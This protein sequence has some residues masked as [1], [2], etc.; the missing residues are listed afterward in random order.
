MP[1]MQLLVQNNPSA[2]LYR[3]TFGRSPLLLAAEA[4]QKALESV[5]SL[6]HIKGRAHTEIIAR[7]LENVRQVIPLINKRFAQQHG[8][9]CLLW[10]VRNG[11]HDVTRLLLEA[12]ANPNSQDYLGRVPL[13]WALFTGDETVIQLL[14]EHGANVHLRI[15]SPYKYHDEERVTPLPIAILH[16]S[17]TIVAKL[18]QR[19]AG[20]MSTADQKN[21]LSIAADDANAAVVKLLL[22]TNIEID[23]I[24]QQLEVT[25]AHGS[26]YQEVALLLFNKV[27]GQYHMSN[28]DLLSLAFS[29]TRR[30]N[31]QVV[32]CFLNK[33]LDCNTRYDT[34]LYHWQLRDVTIG[35]WPK[36]YWTMVPIQG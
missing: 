14:L 20:C 8:G 33:G 22:E 18:L 15:T 19:G 3:D 27:I 13:T 10:A 32:R 1:F 25:P 9:M 16:G 36:S 4:G 12:G 35:E 7:E 30:G 11:Y 5:L 21:T 17:A 2:V 28:E 34:E 31:N 23:V 26:E 6:A 29:A 24:R